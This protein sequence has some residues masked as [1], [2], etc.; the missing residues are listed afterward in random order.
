MSNTCTQEFSLIVTNPHC[1]LLT[2]AEWFSNPGN[3]R[4]RVKNFNAADWLSG[5]CGTCT[6]AGGT[7]WDG[8]F[9]FFVANPLSP[10]YQVD[11]TVGNIGGKTPL[12]G[13]NCACGFLTGSGWYVALACNGAPAQ[14]I[15]G[16]NFFPFAS[17][18]LQTYTKNIGCAG[19]ATVTIEAYSL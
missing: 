6:N 16:T 8:T 9:P 12:F 7:A 10:F 13:S 1:D 4:L 18:P 11:P 14:F 15:Y 5:G 2:P 19:P 3:C 17:G